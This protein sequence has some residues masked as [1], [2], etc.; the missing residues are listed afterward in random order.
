MA[1]TNTQT[2]HL[3]NFA[4]AGGAIIINTRPVHA[5]RDAV[6][7]DDHHADPLKPCVY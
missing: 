3:E 4:P 5:Q 2:T 6:E 7:E 1:H